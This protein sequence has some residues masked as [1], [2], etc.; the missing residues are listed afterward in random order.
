[1]LKADII[2]RHYRTKDYNVL[3]PFG[4]HGTGIPIVAAANK[5]N[6][7]L[8]D[9]KSNKLF[10]MMLKMD[11]K[12]DEIPKFTD[13]F[14]W[15]QYFPKIALDIDLPRLGCAID[16]R[17]SFITTNLNPHFDSFVRWQFDILHAKKYLKYGK[18][19][20]I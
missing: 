2:A 9:K 12:P 15:I 11:I 10:E 6:D 7:E 5:L 1:M 17:R 8:V 13:P 16:Y 4:F 20:V 3:F 14:Y 18:K 19:L